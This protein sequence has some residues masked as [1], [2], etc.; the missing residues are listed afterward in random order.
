MFGKSSTGNNKRWIGLIFTGMLLGGIASAQEV[1]IRVAPPRA[2][3]ERR[4][5]RPG[6][7]YIWI[8]GYH[9]WDGRAYAWVPGRWERPPRPHARWVAHRYVR[10]GGGWVYVEG[11]WR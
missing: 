4:V 7:D 10:R 2:V 8:D 9:R 5:V 3:V 11:H 6:R 1:V